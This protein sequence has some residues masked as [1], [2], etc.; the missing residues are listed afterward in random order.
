MIGAERVR[1]YRER[2]RVR[3]EW[4]DDSKLIELRAWEASGFE[5]SAP[6]RKGAE[7]ISIRQARK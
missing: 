6:R 7:V 3:L 5:E 4:E 2:H 1:R